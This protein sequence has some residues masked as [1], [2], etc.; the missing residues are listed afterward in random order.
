MEVMTIPAA[1]M[2]IEEEAFCGSGAVKII[3]PSSCTR[4]GSRAF[5]ECDHLY[6]VVINGANTEVAPDAFEDSGAILI[7]TTPRSR[8]ED[9]FGKSI[10]QIMYIE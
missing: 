7:M 4:I 5:A 6:C 1:L 9:T 8:A 3:V 2:E 10:H